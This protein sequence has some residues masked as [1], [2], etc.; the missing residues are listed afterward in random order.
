MIN[1]YGTNGFVT[2]KN[3]YIIF[4]SI[5]IEEL[6]AHYGDINSNTFFS[7]LVNLKQNGLVTDHIK[8]FQQLILRVKNISED[9]LLDLFIRTLKHNIQHEVCLFEPSPIEKDF[10]ME[11][12]VESKNMMMNT[13][14]TSSNIYRE[15]NVP[16]YKPPQRLTPQ[17]LDERRAK[18]LC[19]NC[20]NKYSKGHKCGENKLFYIECKE[21]EQ[22]AQDPTQGH[23]LEVITPTISY[24]TFVE[25]STSQNLNIE[26]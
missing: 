20:D 17:Q 8:Q 1:L 14:K 16:S 19:F 3:D 6:I 4:W 24:H 22:K 25:I 7:Q 23:K 5:F 15:N 9:N 13:R 11:M 12:K 10:M 21:E 2:V 18:G 26:G